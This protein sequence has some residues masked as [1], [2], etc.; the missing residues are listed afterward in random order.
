MKKITTLLCIVLVFA[1]FISM[2]IYRQSQ[3][4]ISVNVSSAIEGALADSILAS[5]NLE[6]KTQI[7][8]RSEITGRVLD[9]FVEEGDFVEEGQLL[10][11]LDATSFEADV[12]RNLALVR[13]QEIDIERAKSYLADIKRQFNIHE[14]LY[15]N[16]LVQRETFEGLQSQLDIAKIDV[17]AAISALEQGQASLALAQD[18]FSK[19][20]YLASISGLLSTVDIKPGETVI[21][22]STNIVGSPLMTLADPSAILA[23]LRVDEADIANVFLGQRVEVFVAAYPN[24]AISGEVVQIATSARHMNQSQGL[25]FRVK[26][27]LEPGDTSLYSGMSCRAEI[28]LVEQESSLQVPIAAI[29]RKG[30]SAFVWVVNDG[31]SIRRPVVLGLATD[32]MQEVTEGLTIDDKVI[33]GPARAV[34]QLRDGLRIRVGSTEY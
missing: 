16:G 1:I 10:M 32:V 6:F 28:I 26:V 8:I 23:E 25:S 20:E 27:L 17:R 34:L 9:V 15:Q 18:N 3:T 31:F 29:Q 22:G 11:R 30:D 21:A 2:N 24:R 13:S 33:I 19:T 4:S 7:Q 5:G 12:N 14:V